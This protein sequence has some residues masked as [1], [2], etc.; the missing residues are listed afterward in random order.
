MTLSKKEQ[1]VE[2]IDAA[3]S[4]AM[5]EQHAAFAWELFWKFDVI[6]KLQ[7]F[8]VKLMFNALAVDKRKDFDKN[9]LL[10]VKSS[11]I[12][13]VIKERKKSLYKEHRIKRVKFNIYRERIVSFFK[14]KR[15]I[16]FNSLSD[17]EV[18]S[19]LQKEDIM[20]TSESIYDALGVTHM[21][22]KYLYQ[23]GGVQL[24]H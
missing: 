12:I 16:D 24:Q 7:D 3:F 23:R 22:Y 11:E 18:K 21:Q 13:E 5:K 1:A 4:E 2:I 8:N 17:D 9:E 14:D 20:S 10:D 6:S 15:N 19:L